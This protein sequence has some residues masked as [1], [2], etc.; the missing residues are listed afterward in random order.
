MHLYLAL[1]FRR[2]DFFRPD[3]SPACSFVTQGLFL[4]PGFIPSLLFCDAGIISAAQI[5]PQL[6]FFFRRDYFFRPDSSPASFFFRRDDFYWPDSSSASFFLPQGLFLPARFI[7]SLLFSS[8]GMISIGQI[9]PQL[10]FSFR[11]DL[12]ET[13][14]ESDFESFANLLIPFSFL[15][16]LAMYPSGIKYYADCFTIF[17]SIL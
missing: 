7:P 17:L 5:H 10:A 8:A 3:S 11:R 14:E 13:P 16:R 9:Y 1:L 2:D 15:I 6:A 4:P 12:D